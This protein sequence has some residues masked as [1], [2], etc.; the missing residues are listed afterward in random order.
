MIL[1]RLIEDVSD[2]FTVVVWSCWLHCWP[3]QQRQHEPD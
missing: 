3:E 2:M 1:W